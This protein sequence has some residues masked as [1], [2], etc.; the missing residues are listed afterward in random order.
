MRISRS[1]FIA[2]V[3][4]LAVAGTAAPASADP[5]Y[6][7]DD[8]IAHFA[9]QTGIGQTRSLSRTL[10]IGTASRCD[11]AGPQAETVQPFDLRI[12]FALGSADL[13]R[14]AREDLDQFA[15]AIAD[16]RL[17]SHSF[18]VDGHTDMRGTAEFNQ[19]L[20][21]LRA[22]SVVAY[23]GRKGIEAGRL[24]P[25]GFGQTKPAVEDGFADVNRRVETSI[26]DLAQ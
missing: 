17:R 24:T 12:T 23:L 2:A 8:I 25:R 10:C 4:A 19:R 26:A 3:A 18:Y 7:A 16:E 22:Q 20:S 21:E 6:T 13:T 15:G 11:P 1:Y 9:D 14:Q 5:Q